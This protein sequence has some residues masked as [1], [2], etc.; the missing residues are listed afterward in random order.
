MITGK[1][2]NGEVKAAVRIRFYTLIG[3]LRADGL[4]WT[5]ISRY[6]ARYYDFKIRS[7]HLKLCFE[8]IK[9]EQVSAADRGRPV[10]RPSLA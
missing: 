5:D 2:K 7:D 8:K 6:L 1:R 3:E 4:N 10:P 9:A